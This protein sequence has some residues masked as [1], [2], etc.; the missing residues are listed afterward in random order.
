[1]SKKRRTQK[2]RTES[3][4]RKILSAAT[5]LF[6]KRGFRDVALEDVVKRTGLTR[7]ALYHH[8]GSKEQLF[9]GIVEEV[10]R[11]LAHRILEAAKVES[12]PLHQLKAGLDAFLNACLDPAVQRILLL[13]APTVLGVERWRSVDADYGLGLLRQAL[14]GAMQAGLLKNQPVQALSHLLLGAL[15]EAG[16]F[17]AQSDEPDAARKQVATVLETMLEGLR[18]RT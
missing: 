4:K 6:A 3:T 13:D 9:I 17:V 11:G 14:E 5:R 1:M 12:D 18:E 16:L 10:E 15:S 7:G 2:E 8:F